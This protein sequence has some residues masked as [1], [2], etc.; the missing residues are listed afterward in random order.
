MLFPG[1]GGGDFKSFSREVGYQRGTDSVVVVVVS[2][3]RCS[4]RTAFD[5]GGIRQEENDL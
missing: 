3:S 5:L 4:D 2:Y 1:G